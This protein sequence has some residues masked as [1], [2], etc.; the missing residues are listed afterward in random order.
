MCSLDIS[1]LFHARLDSIRIK[2]GRLDSPALFLA[3]LVGPIAVLEQ[4]SCAHTP[5][6]ARGSAIF[7][8]SPRASCR[9]TG[10]NGGIR[11]E[12]KTAYG[13]FIFR[14]RATTRAE[15]LRSWLTCAKSPLGVS[16]FHFSFSRVSN[17]S[18]IC[19][20][21][22]PIYRMSIPCMF[23][24]TDT[25]ASI[26]TQQTMSRLPV[27]WSGDLKTLLSIIFKKHEIISQQIV[28]YL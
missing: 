23:L 3:Y 26:F 22:L 12:I 25:L 2:Q 11:G 9:E 18:Y 5:F 27:R 4:A 13:L 16:S 24:S 14:R 8:C 6:L 10:N 28:V 15:S 20:Y 21:V 1:A 7:F 17:E 19:M